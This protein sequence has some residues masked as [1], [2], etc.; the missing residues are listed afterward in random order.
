M[1][2][3]P[4]GNQ[5]T[6]QVALVS[7]SEV[8]HKHGE[9][10][11]SV[12]QSWPPGAAALAVLF[13]LLLLIFFFFENGPPWIRG[14]SLEADSAG[15][16]RPEARGPLRACRALE[17]PALSNPVPSQPKP[18]R[19]E[20]NQELPFKAPSESVTPA[21]PCVIPPSPRIPQQDHDRSG[22]SA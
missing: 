3:G 18:E 11:H 9:Q 8:F 10:T 2:P 12:S 5:K 19:R 15:R 21:L 7:A 4:C 13:L 1:E 6:S 20:C 22:P 14:L 17:D 16:Q